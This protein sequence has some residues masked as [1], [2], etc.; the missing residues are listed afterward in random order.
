[1]ERVITSHLLSNNLIT[2]FQFGFLPG[3]NTVTNLLAIFDQITAAINRKC[4]VYAVFLDFAKAFDKVPHRLLLIK[5]RLYGLSGILITWIESFLIGRTQ[6]VSIGGNSG[7][8]HSVL[9]GVIQGSV[10]G[11]LLFVIYTNDLTKGLQSAVPTWTGW[12]YGPKNGGCPSILTN[13]ESWLLATHPR[14][15]IPTPSTA[16]NSRSAHPLHYWVTL[17][18]DL[19]WN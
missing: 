9:T 13:V 8:W 7:D 4:R 12:P 16:H 10:L 6:R 5:L 18:S 11:P 14:L 15:S 1:M 3:R 19:R 2:N 17:T